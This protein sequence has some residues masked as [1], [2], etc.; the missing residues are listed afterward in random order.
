MILCED[1]VVVFDKGFVVRIVNFKSQY[2]I[3]IQPGTFSSFLPMKRN[4]NSEVF[5]LIAE[6]NWV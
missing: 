6:W 3:W 1:K 5:A 2:M 4:R